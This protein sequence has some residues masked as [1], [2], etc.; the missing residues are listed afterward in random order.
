M[1]PALREN[2]PRQIPL[3]TLFVGTGVAALVLAISRWGYEWGALAAVLF[4]AAFLRTLRHMRGEQASSIAE[5]SWLFV[6]S[7]CLLSLVGLC[8]LI[9]F[10]CIATPVV[11]FL[12][13]ATASIG[14]PG[15]VA[16]MLSV[17]GGVLTAAYVTK[18]VGA[19]ALREYF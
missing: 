6:Q 11:G 1:D 8:V 13:I 17:A 14:L 15:D 7:C 12:L 18:V 19:E 10:V 16:L 5:Q 2:L 3:S 4:G 9:T